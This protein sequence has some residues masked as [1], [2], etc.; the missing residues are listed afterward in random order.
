MYSDFSANG[1]FELNG[2]MQMIGNFSIAG[3][4]Q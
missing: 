4:R 2:L 1:A 3:T